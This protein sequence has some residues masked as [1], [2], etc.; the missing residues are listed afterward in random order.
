MCFIGDGQ[1]RALKSVLNRAVL[2]SFDG[3]QYV[4]FSVFSVVGIRLVGLDVTI[5][6]D[7]AAVDRRL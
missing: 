1:L 7:P 3:L 6:P 4:P 2:S 5:E